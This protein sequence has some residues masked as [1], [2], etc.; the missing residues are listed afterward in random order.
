MRN[1]ISTTVRGS[2]KG[3]TPNTKAG[4]ARSRKRFPTHDVVGA[5]YAEHRYAAQLLDVLENS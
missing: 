3:A 4:S 2:D 1:E 5:L